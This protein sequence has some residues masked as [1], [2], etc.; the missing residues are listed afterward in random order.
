MSEPLLGKR[1]SSPI[2]LAPNL[3]GNWSQN[4]RGKNLLNLTT[5]KGYL[6]PFSRRTHFSIQPPKLVFISVL[7]SDKINISVIL[8]LHVP[9]VFFSRSSE[10]PASLTVVP[11]WGNFVPWGH[12]KMSGDILD[13]Y[14]L[15]WVEPRDVAKHPTMHET[16]PQQGSIW[17]ETLTW[18]I[19][20]IPSFEKQLLSTN[21]AR[22]FIGLDA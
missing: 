4:F 1:V 12:L 5:R 17:P 7:W 6:P 9:T 18:T 13:C 22:Y 16:D 8:T 10:M 20:W 15:Q 14:N 19:H 11:T 2:V 3:I 21:Y